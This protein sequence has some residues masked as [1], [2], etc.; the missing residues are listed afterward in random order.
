MDLTPPS[1]TLSA[2]LTSLWPANGKLVADTISGSIGDAA[3]GVDPA[4][5][6]FR[7]ID[8][9]GLVQPAGSVTIAADGH[10]SFV[11]SL[12]ASR[13]GGDRD[14]RRYEIVVSAADTAGNAMSA[15]IIVVVPHD[16]GK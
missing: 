4:S 1:E 10:F 2:S 13:Q 9:Y 3:A 8:E 14:G 5:V 11:V 16:Q 7:V 12:E 6:R 15:S